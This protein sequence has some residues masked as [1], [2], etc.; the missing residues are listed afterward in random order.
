[1]TSHRH[2]L[3]HRTPLL[4]AS[5]AAL[6]LL[7]AACGGSSGGSTSTT[8][9]TAAAGGGSGSVQVASVKNL[10]GTGKT[11][12]AATGMPLYMETDET[13]AMFACTDDCLKVW[14]PLT[15]KSGSTPSIDGV[16]ASKVSTAKRSD[17]SMQVVFDG[18][19]LYTFVLDHN[20]SKP[21]GNGVTDQFGGKSLHWAAA[22]TSGGAPAPSGSS[23]GYS[24]GGYGY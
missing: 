22:T 9:T 16:A 10:S 20:P 4:A 5:G 21:A 3:I 23:S 8:T 18:H 6:A 24:K 13:A 14:V 7:L 15:V 2:A 19:P 17:G 11:L 12:V 1:M